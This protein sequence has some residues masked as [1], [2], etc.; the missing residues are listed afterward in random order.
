VKQVWPYPRKQTM[1][2][3]DK[4]TPSVCDLGHY[5]CAVCCA[6]LLLFLLPMRK[7]G[8]AAMSLYDRQHKL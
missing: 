5:A 1:S 7:Q 3:K 2:S 8:Y 4:H 6:G